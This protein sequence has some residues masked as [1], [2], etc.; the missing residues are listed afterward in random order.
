M[1][2]L[3]FRT[4]CGHSD[5]FL[6]TPYFCRFAISSVTQALCFGM[7]WLGNCFDS[8]N[9]EFMFIP[10]YLSVVCGFIKS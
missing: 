6:I 2:G 1:C 3:V 9:L 10:L 5:H 4:D 8:G 7:M